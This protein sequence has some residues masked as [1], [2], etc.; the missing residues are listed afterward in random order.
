MRDSLSTGGYV[1]LA[2][3]SRALL[4]AAFGVA[5]TSAASADLVFSP[6]ADWALSVGV[7]GG[8]ALA[9]W[10]PPSAGDPTFISVVEDRFDGTLDQYVSFNRT[11]MARTRG[12]GFKPSETAVNLCNGVPA[13]M[14]TFDTLSDKKEPL[15]A[16]QL[17]TGANKRFYVV[18]YVRAAK[19]PQSSDAAKALTGSCPK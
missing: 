13:K 12:T 19:D 9:S 5:T 10:R 2:L 16:Q 1:M 4:C 15:V 18:S 8:K 14:L 7:M 11:A 17:Y 3:V 6:P